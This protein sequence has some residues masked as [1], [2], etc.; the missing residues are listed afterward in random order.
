[1][2]TRFLQ[3]PLLNTSP[4]SNY[5]IPVVLY[6]L[7]SLSFPC[8]LWGFLFGFFVF[9]SL[10]SPAEAN[11]QIRLSS[12]NLI[13]PGHFFPIAQFSSHTYP[14]PFL[15]SALLKPTPHQTMESLQKQ[16]S[17]RCILQPMNSS[18]PYNPQIIDEEVRNVSLSM[19]ILC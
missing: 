12:V 14:C 4:S 15:P 19:W 13:L 9:L 16:S 5:H 11:N 2:L 1:M 3:P 10:G 7:I 18:T 8:I 6:L 17:F